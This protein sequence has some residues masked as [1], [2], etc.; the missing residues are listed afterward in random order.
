MTHGIDIRSA[1]WDTDRDALKALRYE[2]FVVGQNVPEDLEW[3]GEDAACQ[4][5]L[6]FM[7]GT[8]VGTGRLT[9][10]GKIGR[11]AVLERARGRGVGAGILTH[12][13]AQARALGLSEVRLNA[14]THA[15]EFYARHGFVAHGDEFD[16]AGI[17]HRHMVCPLT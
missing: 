13:M 11:M 7:D 16:E 6:A 14:Q 8:V 15:L 1:N 10:G 9:T 4:H 3:D 17:A 5:A 2:V 12:L